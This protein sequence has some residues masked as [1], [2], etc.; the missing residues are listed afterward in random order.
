VYPFNVSFRAEQEQIYSGN[1]KINGIFKLPKK[2]DIQVSSIYLAPDI[3]PQGRIE[4]RYSLD[5]GLKKGIQNGKGELF[6][7]ASDILNTMRIQKVVTSTGFTLK[8]R[9]LYET[10]IVRVGYAYK[11]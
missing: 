7:N 10:Q 11:F 4:S 3:I 9:D 8:S 6:A 2:W 5:L 1:M